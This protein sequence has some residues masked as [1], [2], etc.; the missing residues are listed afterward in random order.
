[1]GLLSPDYSKFSK[2]RLEK[3]MEFLEELNLRQAKRLWKTQK[4]KNKT[5]NV[6]YKVAAWVI[7]DYC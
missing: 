3:H 7:Q 6:F 5:L 2:E 1:M 4:R